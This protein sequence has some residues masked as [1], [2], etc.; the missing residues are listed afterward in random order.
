[1]DTIY[2]IEEL[3]DGHT[4]I[5]R[6]HPG[7]K[8]G[9]T[10]LYLVLVVS[11][12]PDQLPELCVFA[13]YPFIIMAL[14]EIP[15]SS[16]FRRMVI[17]LPFSF[18]AGIANVFLN[19]EVLFTLG[20]IPVTAGVISFLSIMIKTAF[21][22]MAVLI[23]IAT[24][25]LP[26]IACRLLRLH[27]PKILVEDILLTYRYI[28]VLLHEVS[29]MNTAYHLRAPD[30]KYIRMQDMGM[31]LGQLLLR[32]VDRAERIYHAM[33]CRGYDGHFMYAKPEA[34]TRTDYLFGVTVTLL[35]LVLRFYELIWKM[36]L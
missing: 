11:L 21:C 33:K 32:S 17:A 34:A 12:P 16:L 31:F 5:H 35:L 23:L 36:V 1:M 4:F 18:M 14:A 2:S 24:T 28:S 30:E 9:V 6:L 13:F 10:F 22:V 20:M 3:A 27:V 25:T 26:A 29:S 7:V 19:R 15:W 8:L